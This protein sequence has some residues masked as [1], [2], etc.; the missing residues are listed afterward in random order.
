MEQVCRTC[1]DGK[2]TLVDIFADRYENED[3]PTLAEML[4]NCTSCEVIRDDP[5]PQK[6]C[7]SCVL[8]A[9]HFFRF[10]RKCEES[11]QYFWQLLNTS[12]MLQTNDWQ[13]AQWAKNVTSMQDVKEEG[14]EEN[15]PENLPKMSN[16]C[17]YKDT[18]VIIADTWNSQCF[19]VRESSSE[20]VKFEISSR[21]SSSSKD[22]DSKDSS[23]HMCF[24]CD[25]K[26]ISKRK[27]NLHMRVHGRKRKH[28]CPQCEKE[29]VNS[30]NLADHI[31]A[32]TGER[33]Y[34]CPH[35][36]KAFTQRGRLNEHIRT[37][38]GE[39]PFKCLYCP[40]TFA[41]SGN[42]TAHSRTHTGEKP[43]KC[44]QCHSAYIQPGA[45]QRHIRVHSGYRPFKCDLCLMAFTKISY[46]KRHMNSHPRAGSPDEK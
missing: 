9:Q 30:G 25:K 37:H 6:M 43:Y 4:T 46:L 3:E 20:P 36:I 15:W 19:P 40:K 12:E 27:L 33:P 2:A 22:N 42:L 32:H 26:F 16:I 10:K 31:R 7:M 34:K 1:R 11:R 35:C 14:S 39:R 45:L 44:E 29:F 38:T 28:K 18:E 8:A 17:E 5:L 41:S 13:V 21:S 24:T 23:S